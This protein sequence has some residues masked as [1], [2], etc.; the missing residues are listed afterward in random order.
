M[1]GAH[2]ALALCC[3]EWTAPSAPG[4]RQFGAEGAPNG[5]YEEKV[6]YV[7]VHQRKC[8]TETRVKVILMPVIESKLNARSADFQANA[9]A[10]RALVDDLQARVS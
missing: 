2:P 7:G 6:S 9:T 1:T 10:M 4:P 8:A 5:R 3:G